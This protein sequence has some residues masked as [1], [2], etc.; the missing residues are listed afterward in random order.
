[1]NWVIAAFVGI[2]IVTSPAIAEKCAPKKELSEALASRFGEMAFAS[3]TAVDS[4]VSF[5]GNPRTGT[6]SVVI[7]KSDGLSCVVAIGEG[8]EVG[9][10]PVNAAEGASL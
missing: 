1:M 4:A 8:L 9:M 6:W 10:K 5:Y 3:G 7:T 2:G